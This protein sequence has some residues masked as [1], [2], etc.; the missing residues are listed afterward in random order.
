MALTTGPPMPLSLPPPGFTR[1][2]KPSAGSSMDEPERIFVKY[3]RRKHS[4]DFSYG[5]LDGNSPKPGSYSAEP[6]PSSHW[7]R[8]FSL[9]GRSLPI[10]ALSH[11]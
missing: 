6:S 4:T 11:A 2:S 9:T 3:L 7:K 1:S 10:S 5:M 8:P